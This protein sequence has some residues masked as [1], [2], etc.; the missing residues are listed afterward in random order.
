MYFVTVDGALG[1]ASGLIESAPVIQKM[2]VG[3]W[4]D[5]G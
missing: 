1:R 5:L 2:S 4:P 3:T